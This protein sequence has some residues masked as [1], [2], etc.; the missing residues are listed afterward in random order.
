MATKLTAPEPRPP[1]THQ[2]ITRFT[3][4][5]PHKLND[6]LDDIVMNRDAI[7]VRYR[8]VSLNVNG[9]LVEKQDTYDELVPLSAWTAGFKSDMAAAYAKME[10]DAKGKG[11]IDPGTDEPL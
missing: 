6:T 3:V 1:V 8:V 7:T 4:E 11:L 9:D 10:A 5:V 2:A